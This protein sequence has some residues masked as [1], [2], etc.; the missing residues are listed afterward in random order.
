M[1]IYFAPLEGI[2]D[3]VFRRAHRECFAG[4]DKYFIPFITPNQHLELPPRDRRAVDPAANAGVPAVPQILAKDARL[5]L[6]SAEYLAG[7]GYSEVNLN[8]GCPSGTVAAKG[9]GSG[10]LVDPNALRCFLDEIFAKAPVAISVKTRIGYTDPEE[11]PMLLS[12]LSEYPL[13][14]L[15]IHPRVRDEFYKGMPH[16]DAFEYAVQ[17]TQLPLV[18]NGDLFDS[19]DCLD[20]A[21][22]F[23]GAGMMLGRGIIAN[24]ALAE[25]FLGTDRLTHARLYEFHERLYAG[26]AQTMPK[27]VLLVRMCAIMEYIG[28][29]FEDASKAMKAVRKAKDND[30]YHTAVDK[31][32]EN[33]ALLPQPGYRK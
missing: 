27:N 31:L 15:I 33:H 11:W 20:A 21:Q 3:V 6:W 28:C 26:Y 1:S 24:P 25:E 16:M 17:H 4:V 2:T 19:T 30:A 5:F 13:S 14:E 9:K 29:C 32:F 10:M 12:I 7:L 8:L 22:R 18:Y 23:P